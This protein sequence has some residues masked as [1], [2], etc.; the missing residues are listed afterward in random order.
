MQQACLAFGRVARVARILESFSHIRVKSRMLGNTV[1]APAT[2][3]AFA[4][5]T[6]VAFAG[7][8][9]LIVAA[10]F[11]LTQPVLRLPRQ[12]VSN[13]EAAM[14][15]ACV[16]FSLTLIWSHGV[17][18]CETP[19]TLPW[20]V[21]LAA[22]LIASAASTVSRLN[23]FHMT[24]RLTA[25]FCV[26]LLTINGATT[27]TRL[28]IALE[29][30]VAVGVLVSV[31]AMLEYLSV[32]PVLDAL[33]AFRPGITVVGAQLR[34][35]GPLQY[36]TITSMYLEIVFAFG[37]GL[38]LMALD[39]SRPIRVAVLFAALLLIAEA[40][41]LTFTRAGLITMAAS[42]VCVGVVRRSQ[43]GNDAGTSL[44]VA[45][46]V[47]V[48]ALFAASRSTESMWLRLTSEGQESWY[49]AKVDA[50]AGVEFSTGGASTV[51]VSVTN[52]GRLVW[53]SH[54]DPPIR[55]SYHWLQADGDRFVTFEGAR[56][57]FASPVVPDATVSMEARVQ[58]P[59]QPGRYRLEWDIVQ[60]GRLWF[61]TEPGAVR[62]IAP[63]I[64][65]GP[66]SADPVTLMPPPRP[67][68]RP[69][70]F[71]LWR[72][73]TRMLAAHP[74]LGV[75]PDNFR[76]AYGDYLRLPAADPRLHSNN[77]YLEIL[78]GG[79]LLAGGAFLWLLWRAGG[80]FLRGVRTSVP[81]NSAAIGIAAAGFAIALHGCVDSFVS[82]APTYILFSLTL[83]LAVACARGRETW[84]D[85]HR[86]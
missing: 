11:E 32:R 1:T 78:T 59:G 49:R 21:L 28:R 67:T 75:G 47:L 56:T 3:V 84:P 63:A 25:A 2:T 85:A 24:G 33:K 34:A 55:L 46:A 45:L 23:A 61:S 81:D 30:M 7:V 19:L 14:L 58:A 37:L 53:D 17:L 8:A 68:V 62:A 72:A 39:R 64:V 71:A 79:G 51:P 18:R 13:L 54:T 27:Q 16:S 10:P 42:L 73:A 9:L 76:L 57:D 52:I 69:G 41:T 70:R 50:P 20:L 83:G 12:S 86:V 77:M 40:I 6:T 38:L 4:T 5:A 31:I 29:L 80:S 60:E 48:A 74:W 35:G 26:F 44:L 43:R 36:P 65:M 22:M 66:A 15:L 82:F